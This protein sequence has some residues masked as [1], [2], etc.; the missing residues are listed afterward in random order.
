MR[1]RLATSKAS[2]KGGKKKGTLGI[3]PVLFYDRF[4]SG[5]EPP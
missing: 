3:V 2:P 4:P 5:L 1:H